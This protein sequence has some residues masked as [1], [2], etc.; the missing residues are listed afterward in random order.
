MRTKPLSNAAEAPLPGRLARLLGRN[1][2]ANFV[3][4]TYAS[5]ILVIDYM[6]SPQASA[7]F[8]TGSWSN[9]TDTLTGDG[10]DDYY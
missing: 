1:S 8:H 7:A 2:L 6:Y 9:A 10:T 4:L 3:Y 5:I